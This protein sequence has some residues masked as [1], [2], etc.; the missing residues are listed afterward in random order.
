MP[1]RPAHD[2]VA[3]GLGLLA[4]GHCARNQSDNDQLIEVIGGALG[5]L[6]GGR[7]PDYINP[8]ILGPHHRGTAHSWGAA[9]AIVST[10]VSALQARLRSQAA[11]ARQCL[12]FLPHGSPEWDQERLKVFV[13]TL[14]AGA[15]VGLATGY[16]SHLA[17]DA[18]TRRG[19]PLI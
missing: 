19:L 18:G 2:V 8:S 9:A 1:K 14:L 13:L 4:V 7:L 15:V 16:L 10:D 11:I 12:A 5:A 6:L 17:L 3:V